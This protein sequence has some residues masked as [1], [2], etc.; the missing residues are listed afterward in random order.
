VGGTVHGSI[1]HGR[2]NRRSSQWPWSPWRS[3]YI[4]RKEFWVLGL[5]LGVLYFVVYIVMIVPWLTFLGMM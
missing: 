5:L 2:P 3:G 1:G 4:T